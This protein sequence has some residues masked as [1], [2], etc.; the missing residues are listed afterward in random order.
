MTSQEDIVNRFNSLKGY[1]HAYKNGSSDFKENVCKDSTESL[2]PCKDDWLERLFQAC[3]IFETLR[4]AF[5]QEHGIGFTQGDTC[6]FQVHSA[7]KK[8]KIISL[9]EFVALVL[10]EKSVPINHMYLN[11]CFLS[12]RAFQKD[13]MKERVESVLEDLFLILKDQNEGD[14][15]FLLVHSGMNDVF[16]L[17]QQKPRSHSNSSEQKSDI[18]GEQELL[19]KGN[20]DAPAT[21][22]TPADQPTEP[23]EQT[24]MKLSDSSESE[25]DSDRSYDP[26]EDEAIGARAKRRRTSKRGQLG[27]GVERQQRLTRSRASTLQTTRLQRMDDT[28]DGD[29]YLNDNYNPDDDAPAEGELFDPSYTL[30]PT[31]LGTAIQRL[32]KV[33]PLEIKSMFPNL[34][35]NKAS[36]PVPTYTDTV[37]TWCNELERVRSKPSANVTF[38][39][40]EARKKLKEDNIRDYQSDI[41]SQAINTYLSGKTNGIVIYGLPMG[42]GKT[43]LAIFS[44]LALH[45]IGLTDESNPR[46][47]NSVL[48]VVPP[49]LIRQW[50]IEILN[51]IKESEVRCL[52]I[53]MTSQLTTVCDKV[54]YS[55]LANPKCIHFLVVGYQCL[56]TRENAA[57]LL[58]SFDNSIVIFDEPHQAGLKDTNSKVFENSLPFYVRKAEDLLLRRYYPLT[59]FL[60]GTFF[61]GCKSE[62]PQDMLKCWNLNISPN[63]L[64]DKNV[65]YAVTS[66][67]TLGS[68]VVPGKNFPTVPL[69]AIYRMCVKLPEQMASISVRTARFGNGLSPV[70][71]PQLRDTIHAINALSR[72]GYGSVCVLDNRDAVRDIVVTIRDSFAI[73]GSH[74]LALYGDQPVVERDNVIR[75]IE[76]WHVQQGPIVF[77]TAFV[78][79][80]LNLFAEQRRT[81]RGALGQRALFTYGIVYGAETIQENLKQFA[82]RLARPPNVTSPAVIIQVTGDSQEKKYFQ[83]ADF[84]KDQNVQHMGPYTQKLQVQNVSRRQLNKP[85]TRV[86]FYYYAR[87]AF[88]LAVEKLG[89]C[90][91]KCYLDPCSPLRTFDTPAEKKQYFECCSQALQKVMDSVDKV[92]EPSPTREVEQATPKFSASVSHLETMDLDA[93][94]D[95][96]EALQAE[97]SRRPNPD[98]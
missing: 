8:K 86:E 22:A 4:P 85:V 54:S 95:A 98:T 81:T 70:E 1:S 60:S 25:K 67:L 71:F 12:R 92:D 96:I 31:P 3:L 53:S 62:K 59:L 72:D 14:F 41:A 93:V 44:A 40:G 17:P 6:N 13:S 88:A 97:L 9:L 16:D 63:C 39:I 24:E 91:P 46:R 23:S 76:T 83:R 94:G 11:A 15:Q 66:A 51:T 74:I 48:V 35:L 78:G 36:P 58:G 84:L 19:P 7:T 20:S 56:H 89:I 18:Q 87:M 65:A 49:M 68:K 5:N 26:D 29:D 10:R 28:S 69:P 57:K 21:P 64:T 82:A 52:E 43:K 38:A 34:T 61:N 45:C 55:S 30:D 80:G 32:H 27:C 2:R 50:S 90:L 77:A 79:V 37:Q 47:Y 42:L 73:S 33:S 75:Q